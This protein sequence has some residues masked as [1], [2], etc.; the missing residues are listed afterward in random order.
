MLLSLEMTQEFVTLRR[1]LEQMNQLALKRMI[2]Q[3]P[4]HWS[5]SP[6]SRTIQVETGQLLDIKV[7]KAI[8]DRSK[9]WST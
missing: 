7:P 1:I 9:L 3:I 8:R 4:K 6:L 2:V 5:R